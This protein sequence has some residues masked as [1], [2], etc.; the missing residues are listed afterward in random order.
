M[1]TP[2]PNTVRPSEPRV[3]GG[4]HDVEDNREHKTE[5]KIDHTVEDSFP[6]SDPP[7]ASPGAD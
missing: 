1:S 7:S 3:V 5:K 4:P 6:A 2:D